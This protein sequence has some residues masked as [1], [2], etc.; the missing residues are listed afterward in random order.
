[1]TSEQKQEMNAAGHIAAGAG[2]SEIAHRQEEKQEKKVGGTNGKSANKKVKA[3]GQLGNG[4]GQNTNG[5][6]K[7]KVK[8]NNKKTGKEAKKAGKNA[9]QKDNACGIENIKLEP[10]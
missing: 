8:K 2:R 6:K 9:G 1:M 7:T 5:V 3:E 10:T 4:G